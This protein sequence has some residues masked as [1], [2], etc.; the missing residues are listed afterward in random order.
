MSTHTLKFVNSCIFFFFRKRK[1]KK[2]SRIF[3][4]PEKVYL[5]SLTF[6][7]G[8]HINN[9][10]KSRIFLKVA[11]STQNMLYFFFYHVLYFF[12]CIFFPLKKFKPHSLTHL[13]HCIFFILGT[14]KKNTVFLLTHTILSKMT[15]KWTFSR[16]KKIRY[17]CKGIY[18]MK[19]KATYK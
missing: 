5:H 18:F 15:Q 1:K 12:S 19:L 6:F 8:G 13:K 16:K 3:F 4:S 14:R 9:R 7:G 11:V 17:L 2:Y 10:L